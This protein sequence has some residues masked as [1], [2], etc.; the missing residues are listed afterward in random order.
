MALEAPVVASDLPTLEDA[1]ADGDT[2]ILV[3]PADPARL[4]T[5]ILA[6]LADPAAARARAERARERFLQRFTID[7]VAD[8]MLG[9]YDR[10]LGAP[11]A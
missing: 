3:P 7:R 8:Q 11:A 6:T 5:A 9:F 10:A 1:V 2:A 4:A